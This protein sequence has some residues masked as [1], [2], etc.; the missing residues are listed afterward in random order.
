MAFVEVRGDPSVGPSLEASEC[1]EV[2]L[3]DHERV[4]RLCD[5]P[6]PN[7]DAKAWTVLYLYQRGFQ[8]FEFGY[9]SAIAFVLFLITLAGTLV[10][11][12]L[13]GNR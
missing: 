6:A 12:R 1:L 7:V 2:L 11:V 10:Q 9:A 5:D 4:C 3:L 13:Q 8:Y